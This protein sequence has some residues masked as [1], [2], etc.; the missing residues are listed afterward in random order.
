MV[1][2]GG[3][4]IGDVGGGVMSMRIMKTR[5]SVLGGDFAAS[6]IGDVLGFRKVDMVE[7]KRKIRLNRVRPGAYDSFRREVLMR[8]HALKKKRIHLKSVAE[9]WS[10]RR[11]WQSVKFENFIGKLNPLNPKIIEFPDGTYIENE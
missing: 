11:H 10:E 9:W 6:S 2:E 1:F 7:E 5:K 4:E 3:S 8:K